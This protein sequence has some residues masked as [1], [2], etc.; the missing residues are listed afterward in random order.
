MEEL[1]RMAHV[2][3]ADDSSHRLRDFNMTVFTGEFIF[4]AGL[5]GSG[6]HLVSRI[7]TGD[8]IPDSGEFLI[9]GEL[10]RG[11][12]KRFFAGNGIYS[13][14]DADCLVEEM[15]ICE[16]IFLL[17]RKNHRGL[18]FPK[19]TAMIE[20]RSLLKQLGIDRDPLEKISVLTPFEKLMVSLAR[21]LSCSPKLL[22]L[23]PTRYDLSD[24]KFDRISRI[25]LARKE[26]GLSCLFINNYPNL[27]TRISDTM[28]ITEDG[29][30]RR[31]VRF[32]KITPALVDSYIRGNSARA[33]FNKAGTPSS[34]ADVRILLQSRDRSL[35]TCIWT[36]GEITGFYD[37]SPEAL[38][39]LKSFLP[40]FCLTNESE[41]LRMEHGAGKSL[42]PESIRWIPENIENRLL[43]NMSI[44]ENL[45]LPR[46]PRLSGRL[47]RVSPSL[48]AYCA[49]EFLS[50]IGRSD[51]PV[52]VHD[53]SRLERRLLGIFRFFGPDTEALFLDYPYMN[54]DARECDA[55]ERFL[56]EISASG[57][58][59]FLSSRQLHFLKTRCSRIL[60]CE[61]AVLKEIW[62]N[63]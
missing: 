51:S 38:T 2:Y 59:V 47:G 54:L 29:T 46:Y 44:T 31:T 37:S 61:D 42:R 24:E 58:A 25:L 28:V 12:G 39:D 9:N 53:L 11:Q 49:R 13:L 35:C 3:A 63:A 8:L 52:S 30:D 50:R 48:A 43:E 4:L 62:E 27:F 56:K 41:L 10:C 18:I 22:I 45:L 26:K 32:Q 16:N 19:K 55:A 34:S 60:I 17:N 7:L 33:A 57:T 5:H 23:N 6:K 20:T 14:E 1:V 40:R 36:S 15:S 21:I